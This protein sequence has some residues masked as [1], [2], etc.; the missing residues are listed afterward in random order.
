[1][2]TNAEIPHLWAHQSQAHTP[3]PWE[4]IDDGQQVPHVYASYIPDGAICELSMIDPQSEN[5]GV[6]ALTRALANARLIAAAPDLLEALTRIAN[7]SCGWEWIARD[8]IA[9]AKGRT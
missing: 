3:G 8:A 7:G 1:M 9:K 2:T 6:R 4:L 5:D